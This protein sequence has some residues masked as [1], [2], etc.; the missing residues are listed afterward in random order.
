[1]TTQVSPRDTAQSHLDAAQAKLKTLQALN[2]MLID[3]SL[4]EPCFNTP[5][6]HTLQNKLDLLPMIDAFGVQDKIIATLDYQFE[7]VLEVED[8]FCLY[9]QKVG[10]PM[11][12]CFALTA[13]GT[14]TADGYVPDH[15]ELKLA[16]YGI[17]NTMNEIYLLPASGSPVPDAQQQQALLDRIGASVAWLRANVPGEDGAAP[18]IYLNV[19]DLP[20]AFFAAPAFACRVV[21]YVASL[22]EI[23]AL[24]FEEARGTYFPF[25]IAA[26]VAATK[27]LLH[28]DQKLIFHCHAGNGMDNANVIEGLLAGADGYW[29]GMDRESSTIGHAPIS[30]LIANLMRVNNP[31]MEK[32][33]QVDQ[34]LPIAQ[35]MHLINTERATPPTWPIQG[36][37]AYRQMLSDFDQVPTRLMDLPPE[38]IGGKYTFRI[39]PVGSDEQ[40]IIGRVREA[41]GKE[42]TTDTAYKMIL[43]MRD[44]LR[45]GVRIHYDDPIQMAQLLARA[46]S[47]LDRS[48]LRA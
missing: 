42:I 12:G 23:S 6:G 25:Q 11:R 27:A 8:D 5:Y 45:V 34:L 16:P 20:D 28:P 17:P 43:I 41:L 1:M 26:V 29:G 39:A 47:P 18:R 32:L 22:P 35:S 2:P 19:V 30:D 14:L 7:D 24:S 13:V 15:S 37:D 9:L 4:R 3:V 36:G 48:L 31:N 33:Y 21:E 38:R 44:D 10:Y 40:V 46:Q